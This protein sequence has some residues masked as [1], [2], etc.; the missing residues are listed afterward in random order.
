MK[1]IPIALIAFLFISCVTD[2]YDVLTITR[3]DPQY[4]TPT[5]E[6]LRIELTSKD[7]RQFVVDSYVFASSIS[8]PNRIH[9]RP[10]SD[11]IRIDILSDTKYGMKAVVLE[12]DHTILKASG[13][14]LSK[15]SSQEE[16]DSFNSV[17]ETI[18]SDS[19]Q[20]AEQGAAANP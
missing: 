5:K 18:Y 3:C 19:I 1:Y 9:I 10:N 14:A 20:F 7:S 17:F 11:Y 2:S 13:L 12:A 6:I 4:V 15:N 8:H 16:S